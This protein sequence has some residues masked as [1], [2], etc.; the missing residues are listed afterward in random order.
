M[1]IN[2]DLLVEEIIIPDGVTEIEDNYFSKYKNLKRI[3]LPEGI[4]HIGNNAFSGCES[5]EEIFLPNSVT[6][7]GDCVFK[8]CKN[9]K[10]VV[11]SNNLKE[12]P[13]ECFRNCFSLEEIICNHE[14]EINSKC[15][16]NCCSLKKIP[17]FISNYACEAFENCISLTEVDITSSHIPFGCFRGCKN[18]KKFNNTDMIHIIDPFAFSGCENITK[19]NLE[20]TFI[21]SSEAFSNCTNLRKV[22]LGLGIEKIPSRCFY[23]CIN[24]SDINLE[25]NIKSIEKEAFKYCHSI[26]EICLPGNLK[27]IGFGAFSYMDSLEKIYVSP[28]NKNFMTP[29]NKIVIDQMQQKLVLY[30]SGCKDKSY[31]L[32][33]YVVEIDELKRSL[34]RPIMAIGPYAFS[35]NKYLE[36]LNVC[37][38]TS[39]I[40]RT[41]FEGCDS[42][43]KLLVEGIS[44]FTCPGFKIRDNGRYYFHDLSDK[45][46]Y[47]PFEEVEFIGD[48]V[49]IYNNAL[50]NFTNVKKIILPRHGSYSIATNAFKD[51]RIDSIFIPNN[52]NGINNDA[53]DKDVEVIFEDGLK[54]KG[55]I[56]YS[57]HDDYFGNYYLS[58]LDDGTYYIEKDGKRVTI[59]KKEIDEA[60]THSEHIRN[61]P[62]L[63]LD[64]MNDL[65]THDFVKKYLMDGTL[66]GN[67]SNNS[68]CMLFENVDRDDSFFERVLVNSHLLDDYNCNLNTLLN[69]DFSK[70]LDFVEILREYS[71]SDEVLYN[72]LFMAFCS[73]DSFKEL[74]AVD[75][76]L[77]LSVLDKSKLL[78]VS[79]TSKGD[80]ELSFQYSSKILSDNLLLEFI[81]DINTYNI[82]DSFLIDKMFILNCQKPLFKKLFKVYDANVKRALISSGVFDKY[83]S[84]DQNLNDLLN[85][86]EITGALNDDPIIRQRATTFLTEKVFSKTLDNNSRNEY[87]IVSDDIHRIF[88]FKFVREE[89]D[90]EFANFFLEN[91]KELFKLEKEKSGFIERVYNN[92]RIISKT[93]T[94]DKG[95]QRKLK[96]TLDKCIN[97]LSN[98]KFDCVTEENKEFAEFIGAWYDSNEV[99]MNALKVMK[100]AEKAPRN[101]FTKNEII[102]G[103]RVFDNSPTFDLKEEIN[104][105]FSYEWLIKQDKDNLLLGKYCNCCAHLDGAGS[106]IMRASMILDC[107]Q[108]MVI[109]NEKGEI[110]SKATIY[111]NRN[112][113]YAVFNTVETSLN[114]RASEELL[115]IYGAFIRGTKDFLD[116]YNKNNP[117]NEIEKI[118]IGANR[119]TVLELLKKNDNSHPEVDVHSALEYGQYAIRPSGYAG[120]W[121]TSQRLVL[122]R[123]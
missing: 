97:Y 70:V 67:M 46:C 82:T 57:H 86:F 10:K 16:K 99:W 95:S 54:V 47:L 117:D 55:L 115:K 75:R 61:N 34:I 76:D 68:R 21:L 116:T 40:E 90:L 50:S 13:S 92:F 123:K 100:E 103:V 58:E 64:F 93:C 27:N 1:D 96:V 7:L 35:G 51:C 85:L 53:L 11:L 104:D 38:C 120:D 65:L 105:N 108:N 5:L 72:K 113:R 9:L 91:Y 49:Q 89:F 45:N 26:K 80:E 31:S 71:I 109:R 6:S 17:S 24:L 19:M 94:S 22:F 62:V 66:M 8:N 41:A 118:T 36:E 81:K 111:V 32:K 12:L 73:K 2:N 28:F 63:F 3:I 84:C 87:C 98:T 78:E 4:T 121:K 112:D 106:G 79:S 25:D 102:D 14:L 33:D 29:D 122:K 107:C 43:K 39:D 56:S 42:L 110:I 88:N 119:N 44:L 15:F 52:V 23:K 30:A 74:L 48:V 101:I 20:N 59:T 77:L 60:C 69:D 114:H 18:I 37:A 83:S